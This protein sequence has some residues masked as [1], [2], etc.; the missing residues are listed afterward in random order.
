MTQPQLDPH[1]LF[2]SATDI[3]LIGPSA[4]HPV[5][6]EFQFENSDRIVEDMQNAYELLLGRDPAARCDV[7]LPGDQLRVLQANL[8]DGAIDQDEFAK[9]LIACSID[10]PLDQ[11]SWDYHIE[12]GVFWVSVVALKT[13]EEARHFA[14]EFSFN[15]MNVAAQEGMHGFPKTA[16]FSRN[17]AHRPYVAPETV[18]PQKLIADI[19]MNRLAWGITGTL[20]LI[21]FGLA[22]NA[23]VGKSE[24]PEALF[25]QDALAMTDEESIDNIGNLREALIQEK[26]TEA[27]VLPPES[28]V[29]NSAAAVE[30]DTAALATKPQVETPQI[31]DGSS[32][33]DL[34]A[35]TQNG[36]SDGELA[37]EDPLE[38]EETADTFEIVSLIPDQ[39]VPEIVDAEVVLMPQDE[40]QEPSE[41]LI[42]ETYQ[43]MPFT[44]SESEEAL[45]TPA[46]DFVDPLAYPI[47]ARQWSEP[48]ATP[49]FDITMVAMNTEVYA[50]SIDAEVVLR[51]LGP[52][53]AVLRS[54]SLQSAERP[55][56]PL[57]GDY[58]TETI[59]P[60]E[61]ALQ[62]AQADIS[63]ADLGDAVTSVVDALEAPLSTPNDKQTAAEADQE[64]SS[65][66]IARQP[67]GTRIA[68]IPKPVSLGTP[69][70]ADEPLNGLIETALAQL[71]NTQGGDPQKQITP[72]QSG[73]DD[74]A[75]ALQNALTPEA[76]D[77][78]APQTQQETPQSAALTSDPT[79]E[80]TTP[81]KVKAPRLR[82]ALTVTA[83][84]PKQRPANSPIA[85]EVAPQDGSSQPPD[86]DL[87][88]AI[89][90]GL[91]SA[92]TTAQA[93][94]SQID[95][96]GQNIT[97]PMQV[98]MRA[99]KL[100]PIIIS[101]TQPK[102]AAPS[103]GTSLALFSQ[104]VTQ[105]SPK[106]RPRGF[107]TIVKKTKSRQAD[108]AKA[109]KQSQSR[110]SK[111]TV[112]SGPIKSRVAKA[113]T[114]KRTIALN[115]DV[116]IGVFGRKN[117]LKALMRTSRGRYVKLGVGDR[118]G[119]GRV[120]AISNSEL[121]VKKGSRN[122]VYKL[123]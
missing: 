10:L 40:A 36:S 53:P 115:K 17:P 27:D 60:A 94:T 103:G 58:E 44:Q 83:L 80:F 76:K 64:R 112:A 56:E 104:N 117:R 74:V 71:A 84:T 8:P 86:A 38:Q 2:L 15:V 108:I 35:V 33:K 37:L 65:T 32:D 52:L 95:D 43:D 63:E 120:A 21:A 99:P 4:D 49:V 113:A 46:V 79:S 34:F 47:I 107:D 42:E 123:Q 16:V 98:T 7:W 118:F 68:D 23:F 30:V 119:G 1:K 45:A 28:P 5:L 18:K 62:I 89:A 20:G 111:T 57:P 9:D 77:N 96:T 91:A 22:L 121:R 3:R 69:A 88:A 54:N 55:P 61:P 26:L 105:K 31:E 106:I 19:W 81:I 100:R 75:Q 73:T 51:S 29:N 66:D 101:P 90:G 85:Q 92:N 93:D 13:I 67:L 24:D 82:P 50:A 59:V 78:I 109:G 102:V 116:L 87:N 114:E 110:S 39:V 70:Q 25:D 41:P 48:P 122:I 72:S 6:V 14:G 12:S 11:V 97:T